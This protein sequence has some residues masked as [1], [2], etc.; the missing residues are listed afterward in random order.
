MASEKGYFNRLKNSLFGR[1]YIKFNIMIS[2][3]IIILF[4]S[5]YVYHHNFS[6]H[7]L[8]K[9]FSAKEEYYWSVSQFRYVAQKYYSDVILYSIGDTEKDDLVLSISVLKSK[10][11]IYSSSILPYDNMPKDF[12][13]INEDI[14]KNM[15][16]L[17]ED[18]DEYL[19]DKNKKI[20]LK[21]IDDLLSN[22][23]DITGIIHGEE[24]D[25]KDKYMR[26]NL[27]LLNIFFVLIIFVF[28]IFI[29][30][31]IVDKQKLKKQI[32]LNSEI[33]NTA[34]L[35]KNL[36]SAVNHEIR[37]PIHTIKGGIEL[38]K[39][40]KSGRGF[41][42]TINNI[43]KSVLYLEKLAE[44]FLNLGRLSSGKVS[45]NKNTINIQKFF[46]SFLYE[47]TKI[48]QSKKLYFKLEFSSNCIKEIISDETKLKIIIGNIVNN[49]IKYTVH[50]G[51]HVIVSSI[52]SKGK[53]FLQI[54]V[55]DTGIGI[56]EDK[57]KNIFEPFYQVN[58]I[59]TEHG[60]GL[61]LAIAY[62]M[63]TLM[64]GE[65]KIVESVPDKG[66][67]FLISIPCIN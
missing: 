11:R 28:F 60:V 54:V 58:H 64:D 61:G 12:Y 65:V 22:I 51:V 63:A 50:G 10:Y 18:F 2:I 9:L 31:I 56:S 46:D 41:D 16:Y 15:R 3:T 44:D 13:K 27:I 48:A 21:V 33:L 24:L 36:L 43:E 6:T 38:L 49:S 20:Y 35:R 53:T 29:K 55:K 26:Q 45:I 23:S 57:Q 32:Q 7:N 4:S 47:Y 17:V 14:S 66:T 37:T 67:V 42:K 40:C 59:N 39:E 52:L 30:E 5:I 62:Q 25:F 34:I 1:D 19:I 8:S